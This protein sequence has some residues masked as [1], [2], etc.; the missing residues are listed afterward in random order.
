MYEKMEMVEL[1]LPYISG[2]LAFREAPHLLALFAKLKKEKPEVFPQVIFVDGNGILHHRGCGLATHLGVL[3]N[4]PTVGVSKK[5]LMVDGL[6][7]AVVKKEFQRKAKCK[8]DTIPIV[9][10]SGRVWGVCFKGADNVMNPVYVS[11]GHNI[12][13]STAVSLVKQCSRSRI[14]EPVRQADLRS[15]KFLRENG[16]A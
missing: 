5:L 10:K 11:V 1:Q 13:L 2:Y 7:S 14:P 9:G 12:T 3:A 15:R 8:G 4:I 6:E 16:Y